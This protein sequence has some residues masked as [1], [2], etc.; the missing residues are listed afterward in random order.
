MTRRWSREDDLIILAWTMTLEEIAESIDRSEREILER[1][2]QLEVLPRRPQT[3][4]APDV[5]P[6]GVPAFGGDRFGELLPAHQR[7]REAMA[8]EAAEATARRVMLHLV[9]GSID[10]ARQA[11]DDAWQSHLAETA[12][13]PIGRALLDVPLAAVL[14]GHSAKGQRRWSGTDLPRVCNLLERGGILTVRDL[15][16]T[17]PVQ[18]GALP[19][20][21]ET[22]IRFLADLAGRLRHLAA[23]EDAVEDAA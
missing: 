23:Q 11:L 1:L 6:A 16:R 5:P 10:G 8:P 20:V 4:A 22:T 12:S 13:L 21:D 2:R 19:E 17:T 9:R 14:A 3:G 7:S 15:L 18:W